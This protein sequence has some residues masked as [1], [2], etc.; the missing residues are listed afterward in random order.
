MMKKTFGSCDPAI[1]RMI[2]EFASNFSQDNANYLH[3]YHVK[4]KSDH[5]A[6]FSRNRGGR[7]R[8]YRECRGRGR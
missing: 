6:I 1:Q 4:N 8:Q 3:S 7:N 5:P 2:V